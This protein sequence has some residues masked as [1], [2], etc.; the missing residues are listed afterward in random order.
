MI[1]LHKEVQHQLRMQQD[2]ECVLDEFFT[3]EPGMDDNYDQVD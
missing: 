2:N 1:N 3:M